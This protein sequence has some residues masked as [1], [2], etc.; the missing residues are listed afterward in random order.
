MQRAATAQ[1][2]RQGN[3]FNFPVN[4]I[5]IY[6]C[7]SSVLCNIQACL[8]AATTV[9][10]FQLLPIIILASLMHQTWIRG[11][12]MAPGSKGDSLES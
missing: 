12:E 3:I 11:L 1:F 9:C 4:N 6:G 8:L 5:I 7:Q 10:Q 2:H